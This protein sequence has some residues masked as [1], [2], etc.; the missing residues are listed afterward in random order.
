M[1]R[2][3]DSVLNRKYLWCDYDL[4]YFDPGHGYAGWRDIMDTFLGAVEQRCNEAGLPLGS[5]EVFEIMQ[6][7]EKW[8]ALTIYCSGSVKPF[9]LCMAAES[10]SMSVCMF[11]GKPG[12]LRP[13]AWHATLCDTC[14][15]ER[16]RQFNASQTLQ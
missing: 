16:M 2:T 15:A 8:G 13:G 3:Y 7:K 12:H 9:D 14:Q 1:M 11:C 10:A 5:P 4:S 6:L